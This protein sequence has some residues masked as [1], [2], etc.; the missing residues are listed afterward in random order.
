MRAGE[1]S[2]LK[3]KEGE[4]AYFLFRHISLDSFKILSLERFGN[5]IF[6]ANQTKLS[7]ETLLAIRSNTLKPEDFTYKSSYKNSLFVDKNDKNFC[8]DCYYLLMVEST[9]KK[10]ETSLFFGDT[11]SIIPIGDKILF[12]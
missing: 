7:P 12:D 11:M 8:S 6:Y 2:D 9:L 1:L 4:K 3:L 5:L 10:T